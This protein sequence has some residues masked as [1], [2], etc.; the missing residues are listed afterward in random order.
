MSAI[1]KQVYSISSF[2]L[3]IQND[4]LYQEGTKGRVVSSAWIL[5]GYDILLL[6]ELSLSFEYTDVE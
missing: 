5:I 4:Y 2:L 6:M 1:I 3:E